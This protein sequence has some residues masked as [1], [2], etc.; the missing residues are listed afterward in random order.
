MCSV[1]RR[2]ERAGSNARV[3]PSDASTAASA[4]STAL[5]KWCARGV[6]VTPPG[7][8]MNNGS[9]SRSRRRVRPWLTAGCERPSF[10]AA[11]RTLPAT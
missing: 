8:R 3:S 2:S 4:A 6:G 5:E 10:S 9:F 1:K 11:R 7:L